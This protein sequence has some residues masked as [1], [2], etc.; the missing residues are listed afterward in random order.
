MLAD[1]LKVIG[2]SK[3]IAIIRDI[4]KDKILDTVEALYDG[5]IRSIEVALNTDNALKIIEMIKREYK[6]KMVVGAGTVLDPE[7]ARLAILSGADFAL[8]PTLSLKVIEIFNRYDKLAIPGVFTPTEILLAYEAGARVVK[9]FPIRSLGAGY[10]KD[11]KG[12][13][14]HVNIIPVGGITVEN[15]KEYISSGAYA[16]GI[17]SNLVRKE[18]ITENKFDLLRQ[19]TEKLICDLH[20]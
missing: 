7:S 6:E 9:V 2:D 20:S 3:V 4:E 18:L 17:G 19:I 1:T 10:I 16:V 13:L 11:I 15:A 5:G 8:S 14:N 12:P